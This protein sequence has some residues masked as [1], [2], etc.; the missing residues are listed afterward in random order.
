MR[1]GVT[2]RVQDARVNK[3]VE[4]KDVTGGGCHA[5]LEERLGVGK[6]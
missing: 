5:G 1:G 3:T 2:Q 4:V 6:E